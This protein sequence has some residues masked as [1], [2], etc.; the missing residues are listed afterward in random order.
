MIALAPIG[1]PIGVL[2]LSENCNYNL[3][4]VLDK[5]DSEKISPCAG[6]EKK[7]QVRLEI[8]QTSGVSVM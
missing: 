5:H 4:L 1:I 3:N 8:L 2:K 6:A 7:L